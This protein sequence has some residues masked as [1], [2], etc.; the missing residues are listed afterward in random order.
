MKHVLPLAHEHV[1][2]RAAVHYL[3]CP[4][5]QGSDTD[6]SVTFNDMNLIRDVVKGLK[7]WYHYLQSLDVLVLHF[8]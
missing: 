6:C 5:S 4:T 8:H 1:H 2:A 7:L 3:S